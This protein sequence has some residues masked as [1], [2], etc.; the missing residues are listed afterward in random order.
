M[1]TKIYPL[2]ALLVFAAG[3]PCVMSAADMSSDETAIRKSTTD[4]V[5]AWNHQ[6]A[7]AMAAVFSD[8]A[9]LI[10]PSGR[11]AKGHAEIEKLFTDEHT[12][13][14]RSSTFSIGKVDVRLLTPDVAISEYTTD[15]SGMLDPDGKALPPLKVH[16]LM[17]SQK[18]NGKWWPT[19]ARP[20]A[21]LPTPPA[22][23]AAKSS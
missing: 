5:A 8:D 19:L 15:V 12:T 22:P 11:V 7:K 14:M 16:V 13:V 18:K 6:D 3:A 9:D 21:Y 10:N 17:V 20:H 1:K 4:F 2:L 23:P